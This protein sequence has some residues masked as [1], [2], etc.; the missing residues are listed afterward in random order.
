MIALSM[1]ILVLDM[2]LVSIDD[3]R[4]LLYILIC[5]LYLLEMLAVLFRNAALL[6]PR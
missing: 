3:T 6:H 2:H 4:N 5:L 1:Y